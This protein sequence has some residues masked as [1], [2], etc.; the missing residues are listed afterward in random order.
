AAAA[1]TVAVVELPLVCDR[2]AT[3]RREAQ[4]IVLSA[5][6]GRLE[7]LVSDGHS[8]AVAAAAGGVGASRLRFSLGN[9]TYGYGSTNFGGF[10][11]VGGGS[12]GGSNGGGSSGGSGGGG[13]TAWQVI[14]ALADAATLPAARVM[15]VRHLEKWL[16]SP[17]LSHHARTL[18][19]NLIEAVDGTLAPAPPPPAAA[20]AAGAS[21]AADSAAADGAVVEAVLSMRLKASQVDLRTDAIRRLVEK[22]PALL[23]VVMRH[24]LQAMGTA[25]IVRGGIVGGAGGGGG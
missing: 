1:E 7:G 4:D 8:S 2:F 24:T 15:A 16:L 9:W 13:G 21:A 10:G 23:R 18:L 11:S 6:Q 3:T 14:L 25:A 17:A 12:A 22:R 20:A 5:L 19:K